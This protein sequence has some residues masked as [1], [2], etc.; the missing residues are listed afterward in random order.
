MEKK[1]SYRKRIGALLAK[2]GYEIL[3]PW[4]REKIHYKSSQ[5]NN[6]QPFPGDFIRRDLEDIDKCDVFVAYLPRLSAGTCMELFY[7]KLREKRTI[8]ICRLKNPS[9]WIVAHS[10]AIVKNLKEFE[11]V[12][13]EEL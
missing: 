8:T 11:R 7:A 2:Y 10:D 3:D 4:E 5:G 12:L 13:K 1:Q 9:P 6:L